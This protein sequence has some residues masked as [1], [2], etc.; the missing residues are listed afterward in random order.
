MI[1]ERHKSVFSKNISERLN[2]VLPPSITTQKMVEQNTSIF[3]LEAT[4]KAMEISTISKMHD[5][6]GSVMT[7]RKSMNLAITYTRTRQFRKMITD[8]DRDL[9]RVL[10]I[11][12]KIN[13]Y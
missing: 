7:K 11:S 1:K 12:I 2:L 5:F 13:T 8:K 10:L 3:C 9:L 4:T 6:S